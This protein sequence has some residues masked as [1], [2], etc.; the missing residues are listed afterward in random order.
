MKLSPVLFRVYSIGLL[1]SIIVTATLVTSAAD[2]TTKYG[3]VLHEKYVVPSIISVVI[4]VI[5]LYL[6][7]KFEQK[8]YEN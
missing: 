1:L 8:M 4:T 7:K 3:F 6:Y 5:M 2:Y